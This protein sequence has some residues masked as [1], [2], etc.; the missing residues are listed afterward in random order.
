MI[1]SIIHLNRTDKLSNK[2][3]SDINI[4]YG[5]IAVEAK[6]NFQPTASESQFDTLAQLQQYN[7][8]FPNYANPC[9]L[10]QTV[11]DGTALALPSVPEQTNIGLWSKQTSNDDGTFTTPIVLTLT[12][13]GKYTSE[14]LT[15]TFDTDNGIYS[16]HISI[17]WYR[18]NEELSREDFFLD[19]ASYYC[20]NKVSLYNKIEIT[21]FNLNMPQNRLR[22]RSIDYGYGTAFKGNELKEIKLIQEIDP[23]SSE[24]SINTVDFTVCNNSEKELS[25]QEKQ[26]ISIYFNGELKA[27][28]FVNNS[29]RNTK[30]DWKI[31]CEDYI[32]IL[33]GIYYYGGI[34]NNVNAGLIISD[35]FSVANVPYSIED[36]LSAARI[37]GYIPYTTCGEALKQVAFAIQAVVDTSNGDKVRIFSLGNDIKQTIPLDRV[38]QGQK[39]P[40]YDAVTGVEITAHT[41]KAINE[42]STVYDANES[43]IGNDIFVVFSEPMHTLNIVNGEILESGANYAKINAYSGCVLSG[44]KYQ[45][46][47][48]IRTL[49]NPYVLASEV[50]KRASIDGATLVS[51]INV[52]NVLNKCYNYIVNTKEVRFRAVEGK[53]VTIEGFKYGKNKYG[54]FK[55]GNENIKIITRDL[56]INVGDVLNVETEYMGNVLGR[57]IRQ[58]F[59]LSDGIIIKDIIVKGDR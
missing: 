27:T 59:S 6:E 16:N 30:K 41:Y 4:S 18:D 57:N 36:E 29:V 14:G 7:L 31:Q 2:A 43:G 48:N 19:S 13:Y 1:D 24:I 46:T 25:F 49:D 38:L 21:F 26:P 55:Y 47:M 32:G 23:I 50:K 28:V 10:Y 17:V 51:E 5:N 53:H 33:D 22:L 39:F 56:P 9:E 20:E 8:N 54:N 37:S 12:S 34:Y 44:K 3:Q 40:N 11:L 42:E 15:L 35:I 45:H 58:T 52:D